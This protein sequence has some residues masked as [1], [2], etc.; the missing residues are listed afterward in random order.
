MEKSKSKS[1]SRNANSRR[2]QRI[3]AFQVLYAL[4]FSQGLSGLEATFRRFREE[5]S[6]EKQDQETFAWFLVHGVFENLDRLDEIIAGYSKNWKIGRIAKIE[7]TILRLAVYEMLFCPDIPLKV[8]INEA[9][10]LSKSF[11]DGNSRNF[12]NGI[13]DAV[14]RDTKDGK[15][16][17]SKG[18]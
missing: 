14:A 17:I 6:A 15:S 5:S 16:G 7:L 1:R 2:T 12:I 9:I 11:G 10:E 3:Y 8:A 13:L 4:N 18:F